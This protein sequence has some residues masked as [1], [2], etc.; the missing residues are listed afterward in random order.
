MAEEYRP[1][2]VGDGYDSEPLWTPRDVAAYLKV[3]VKRV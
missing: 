3:P 1:E 2:I